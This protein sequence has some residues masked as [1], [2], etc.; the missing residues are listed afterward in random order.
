MG[1]LNISESHWN[2]LFVDIKRGTF[3]L[4]DPKELPHLENPVTMQAFASWKLVFI[5]RSNFSVIQDQNRYLIEGFDFKS[6]CEGKKQHE[7][8]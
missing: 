3:Y 1:A 2:A 4:I 6:F 5:S 7:P 8:H